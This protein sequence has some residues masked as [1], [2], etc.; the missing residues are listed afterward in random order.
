MRFT[1]TYN[2]GMF[3]R[4]DS[5]LVAVA[6]LDACRPYERLVLPFATATASSRSFLVGG[7]ASSVRVEFLAAAGPLEQSRASV[8]AAGRPVFALAVSV[9][10]LDQALDQLRS[11]G[12]EAT[13][14]R[15]GADEFAWLPLH[16]RAGVDLVLRRRQSAATAKSSILKRLDHLATVTHDLEAKTRYWSDVLGIPVAGE[17]T[18]PTL[19][20]RQLR[21][22]DAVLELLGPASP[23]SPLVKRPP[24]L[25]SM[26]SWEVHD[27]GAAVAQAKAAGFTV[28]DPAAGPLPGTR[29]TTIQG[30]VL[31]GVN[32]QLLEYV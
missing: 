12:V 4:I 20:I 19:V 30:D 14:H 11:R 32:M 26:A 23:E 5:L 7:A 22:G 24:G 15:S 10:D 2:L 6:D 1:G 27:M 29:I 17:V 28:P 13:R 31:A 18:T 25:V 3:D 8:L 9:A 16:E 21:I